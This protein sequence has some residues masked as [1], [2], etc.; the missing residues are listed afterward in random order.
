MASKVMVKIP[1]APFGQVS[2]FAVLN[3]GEVMLQKCMKRACDF[4]NVLFVV[5]SQ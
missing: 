3:V 2:H 1:V 4:L 5:Y